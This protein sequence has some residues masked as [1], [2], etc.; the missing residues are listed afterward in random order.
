MGATDEE[1]G[2]A[3]GG[4]CFGL[5]EGGGLR[6]STRRRGAMATSGGSREG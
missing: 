6:S 4:F 2:D 3:P 5:L 1:E